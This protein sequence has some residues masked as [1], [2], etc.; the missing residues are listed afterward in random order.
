[1]TQA[2]RFERPDHP[3][4]PFAIRIVRRS[5]ARPIGIGDGPPG[6]SRYAMLAR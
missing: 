3:V 6:G 2:L 4:G 1:M 5:R